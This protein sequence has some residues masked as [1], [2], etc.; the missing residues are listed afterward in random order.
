[1]HSCIVSVDSW[2]V[3]L[4]ISNYSLYVKLNTQISLIIDSYGAYNHLLKLMISV[5][6]I[7]PIRIISLRILLETFQIE[8]FPRDFKPQERLYQDISHI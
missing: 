5:H 1:M 6:K 4:L 7:S 8:D 3:L 2:L